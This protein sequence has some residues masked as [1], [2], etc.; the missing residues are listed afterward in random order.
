MCS[1]PTKSV[2]LTTPI[3]RAVIIIYES[4]LASVA[5]GQGAFYPLLYRRPF[6]NIKQYGNIV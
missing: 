5:C 2:F 6:N 3:S 1:R 4:S